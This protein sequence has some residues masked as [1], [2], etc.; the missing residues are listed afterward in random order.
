MPSLKNRIGLSLLL[1]LLGA[2]LWEFYGKPVTG[3]LYTAAVNE[4]RNGHYK[5]SLGLLKH[6]Y[7]IDPNDAS[8]LTLMGWNDLKMG[9]PEQALE[10]F[11]RAHRLSPDSPDTILGYADTDIA[12]GRYQHATQL[13]RLLKKQKGDSAD[14]AMAWVSATRSSPSTTIL[15]WTTT[16]PSR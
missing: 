5:S 2:Y 6:A 11:S 1:I 3:P 10:R 13:L 8:V 4:F 14:L 15:A 16:L 12:L 9:R 7:K